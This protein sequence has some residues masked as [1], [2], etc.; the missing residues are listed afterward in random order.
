MSFTVAFIVSTAV[1]MSATGWLVSAVTEDVEPSSLKEKS[2][3]RWSAYNPSAQAIGSDD[4]LAYTSFMG[5]TPIMQ[6][7]AMV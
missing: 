3:G 7:L 4:R 6:K 2:T 5:P 1:V